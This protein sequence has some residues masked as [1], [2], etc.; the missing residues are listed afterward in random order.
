MCFDPTQQ[1]CAAEPFKGVQ[2]PMGQS[3][4]STTYTCQCSS[5]EPR[6]PLNPRQSP[7]A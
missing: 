4:N 1:C 6:A 5:S 7:Q 2:C 3:C